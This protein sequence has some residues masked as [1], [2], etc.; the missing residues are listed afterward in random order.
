MPLAPGTRIGAYAVD[1]LLGAGGMGEVYR[2]RDT[3]LN[4]DVAL[5]VL[6]PLVANDPDR[7]ARFRREAQVLASLNDPHIAQIYGF[8][9]SGGTHALVMELVDGPTLAE[10]ITHGPLPIPDALA[11][12]RQIASALETAHEQGI[13]HRDLKP[14]N[15][16][17]R[18]D[19]T[20]KVLDFGLAKALAPAGELSP[21]AANSPTMS[22]HA[23]ELG[24]I[25]GTAAY[26]APEQA[27]GR[28]VDKRADIWAF[29]VVLFE[30]L[31]GR[32]LFTGE[33]VSDTLAAVLR[34]EIDWTT[35][36][37][38][39]P[40]RVRQLLR[41]CLDRD[42]K[43]RLRDIGEARVL[44][45]EADIAVD[46]GGAAPLATPPPSRRWRWLGVTAAIV[47]A[48]VVGAGAWWFKPSTPVP[49]RRFDLPPDIAANGVRA[50]FGSFSGAAIAPDGS[51]IAYV[52]GGHLYVRALDARAP[53]DLGLA[54]PTIH[55]L[56]WSPD[57]RWIGFAAEHALHRVPA[58]G[59]APFV[60]APIP[61][62]GRILD[63]IWLPSGTIVFSVW[64]G[65]LYQ[66]PAAGGAP[67]VRLAI[68][69]SMDV[70]VHDVS[71]L[72][73]GRLVIGVHRKNK[74]HDATRVELL[75]G[76]TRRVL[77]DD[78]SVSDVQ[79]A[80]GFLLFL[81]S[82]PNRGLWAVPFTDGPIDLT[83]AVSVQPG[84]AGY[85]VSRDGTLLVGL[86]SPERESLVWVDRGGHATP[87]P[88]APVTLGGDARRLALSP[89]GH[90]VAFIAD[91][92]DAT[93]LVVRDLDTGA[94][95]PLTFN[96]APV[97]GTAV[98]TP[99]LE[100]PT[101]RPAG[102]RL[103][104]ASGAVEGM[105]ILEQSADGSTAP[106]ILTNAS[107]VV[108]S[109][110]GRT[111]LCVVDDRGRGLL[112]YAAIGSDGTPGPLRRVFQGDEPDVLFN[113]I[114]LSPDGSTLAVSTRNPDGQGNI[115]LTPFPSA[116]RRWVVT[117]DGGTSPR[118]SADGRELF[119]L[120]G[121]RDD[122]GGLY[123][124]LMRVPVTLHPSVTIGVPA[125]LVAES[126]TLSLAGFSVSPDGQRFLMSTAAPAA[127]GEGPRVV[128]VQNWVAG[129]AT[130][131][132]P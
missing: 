30:M 55:Q 117:T 79:Y 74:D 62:T 25:L 75:D 67:T 36:P 50:A 12:A 104:Y 103:A 52:A 126:D 24:M 69:P 118:F 82:G 15:V 115:F 90:R 38:D 72:P 127:A 87:A 111:L 77:T 63:A 4:R 5:K 13:V 47:L 57:S 101:W 6:P 34:Q 23:T 132:A 100:F 105:K 61:E 121:L 58:A 110:D 99:E 41:R 106:R 39:T 97:G 124:K 81:R 68:D 48:A 56:F 93:N 27:R 130:S 3:K 92:N 125:A 94:D 42:P 86:P 122:A 89:D 45:S 83:K 49:L 102:D 7:L 120:S 66:V 53:R 26:M 22:A 84:A 113:G 65:S 123:G 91:I 35:L 33:T 108:F 114:D 119:Y 96:R 31:T 40:A 112:R 29:G 43:Q 18:E 51:A 10:R 1:A 109:R 131:Q 20:V 14:A 129:L 85:S 64:R 19:G 9:D 70:D 32:Q 78:D 46:A 8:E 11:I 107:A 2:A 54:A 71:A 80:S 98:T 59:G 37:N 128:L 28:S 16:K 76:A 44:L 88:G 21:D 60:I 116:D 73:N 17:V 95:R